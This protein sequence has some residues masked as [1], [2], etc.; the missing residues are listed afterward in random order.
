[1]VR[2]MVVQSTNPPFSN[3]LFRWLH[4]W[5]LC[6]SFLQYSI[7]QGGASIKV[8]MKVNGNAVSHYSSRESNS[9]NTA[10]RVLYMIDLHTAHPT[11]AYKHHGV[12]LRP[13]IPSGALHILPR[14]RLMRL[15]FC[16]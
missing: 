9:I 2:S 3:M 12:R 11:S 4:E 16:P 7:P 8:K 14:S 5:T 6:T 15:A 1:M 13:S 10:R